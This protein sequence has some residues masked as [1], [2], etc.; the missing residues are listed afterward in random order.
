M[1]APYSGSLV[2]KPTPV[3]PSPPTTAGSV[4]AQ[5]P[6][7]GTTPAPVVPPAPATVIPA[8]SV[9]PAPT[10]PA[11][12]AP[13]ALTIYL[14]KVDKEIDDAY[15]E[16][17]ANQSEYD[18]QILTLASGFLA[19]T[20]VFLKDIVPMKIAAHHW[21]LYSAWGALTACIVCVL[22]SYQFSIKALFGA[23]DYWQKRIDPKAT[24]VF[25]TGHAAWVK[26]IN[27][28]SGI[29]FVGGVVL[30]VAFA[31]TNLHRQQEKA[32]SPETTTTAQP[33]NQGRMEG[34]HPRPTPPTQPGSP[35]KVPNPPPPPPPNP[36]P[37]GP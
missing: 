14:Q 1:F 4:V 36:K 12:L 3:G 7:G 16:I 8:V 21:L 29:L 25:P 17:N 18:K 28:S 26:A 5:P 15:K 32:M 35:P 31:I 30:A 2:A 10:A 9:T 11:A 23:M 37:S 33:G 34:S 6:A 27:I 19:L 20:L 13:D 24:P 22:F